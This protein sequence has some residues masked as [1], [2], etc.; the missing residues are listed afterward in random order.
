MTIKDR[1]RKLDTTNRTANEIAKLLDCKV[2]TAITYLWELDKKY[3]LQN[4]R[5]IPFICEICKREVLGGVN[6][7][8]CFRKACQQI[9]RDRDP[10][11]KKKSKKLCPQCQKY[12]PVG[13]FATNLCKTCRRYNESN[14]GDGWVSEDYRVEI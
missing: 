5:D 2:K 10:D 13:S 3:I 12:R 9:K 14:Y 11:K 7:T 1:L 6:Q 4:H 8:I